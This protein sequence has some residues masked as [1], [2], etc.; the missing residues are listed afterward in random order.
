MLRLLIAKHEVDIVHELSLLFELAEVRSKFNSFLDDLQVG[1][2]F[3][4]ECPFLVA[5]NEA[6]SK[7]FFELGDLLT[8]GGLSY[9]QPIG[10]TSEIEF[11]G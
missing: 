7:L 4:E 5:D 11:F 9:V 10:G 1:D 3:V 8:E 6:V 2:L